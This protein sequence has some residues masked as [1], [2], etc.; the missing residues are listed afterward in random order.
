[1]TPENKFQ[2]PAH[3]AKLNSSSPD[4]FLV[5]P[6]LYQT[7]REPDYNPKEPMGL[8]SL[9]A[10]LRK[11]NRRVEIF[12]ADI[13]SKTIDQTI[14]KIL[15]KKAPLTGFSVF[16]RALPSL[17]LIVDGLREKGYKGHITCGGI[18]PT[19]SFNYILEKLGDKIDSIVLGEGE[20]VIKNLTDRVL[21]GEDW[22][23][24]PSLAY[25][26]KNSQVINKSIDSVDLDSLPFVARDYLTFCLN[27]TNYAT[28]M[29]SR[30]CYGICTFCSNYSFE[31]LHSGPNW[32]PKTPRKVVDEME[33]LLQKYKVDVF[34][35]NDPN[36]FGPGKKG[37]EHVLEICREIK[38]R[39]LSFHLMGFCRADDIGYDLRLIQELKSAGF[40]RLLIGIES[41]D[42]FIIQKFRK[43]E[44]IAEMGKTIDLVQ[45]AG[46][47][48]VVGF[49]IFNPYTTLE[50]LK[51]DLIFLKKKNLMPTLTKS[52]RVFDGTPIQLLLEKEGRLVKKNPFE[53]YHDY[54]MP[55]EIA[56]IYGSMKVLF[57]NC[58]DRVRSIGQNKVWD[59]KKSNSFQKRQRFD[60]LT[61]VFFTSESLLLENLINWSENKHFKLEEVKEVID[62][63][64]FQLGKIGKTISL[65]IKSVISSPSTIAKEIF[66]LMKEKSWNTFKEEYRWNED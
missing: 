13:E 51:K 15:A 52:L 16:Q 14:D 12:D 55:P 33:E 27:K 6:P 50:S 28:I 20:N 5:L 7:G 53:G 31:K 42:D 23:D 4:V 24:L 11:F 36:I 44:T 38:K 26:R 34:K 25:Y 57:V 45:K 54:L 37:K 47:S 17:S 2:Y 1:M 46:I 59:I 21:N 35:F 40:E 56:S 64:Y 9:A 63:I 22:R 19:L 62:K 29:G 41:S 60:N 61:E 58:I 49:M 65:E 43:G 18:T 66:T 32:R 30:G 39:D 3:E 10:N 48:T 8:M